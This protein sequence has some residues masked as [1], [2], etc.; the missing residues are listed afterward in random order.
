M[1]QLL[2]LVFKPSTGDLLIAKINPMLSCISALFV[3]FQS[4]VAVQKDLTLSG[5]K[6]LKCQQVSLARRS[7]VNGN[8]A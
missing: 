8:H 3:K 7:F 5:N 2:A 6:M 4:V 1:F